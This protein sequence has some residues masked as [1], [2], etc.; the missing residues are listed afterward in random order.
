MEINIILAAILGWLASIFV[1]ISSKNKTLKSFKFKAWFNKQF[2]RL[3][4]SA[5]CVIAGVLFTDDI[6]GVEITAF[7][8]FLAAFSNDV[9]LFI[10]NDKKAKLMGRHHICTK[11]CPT[12]CPKATGVIRPD[13][14][15]GRPYL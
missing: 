7:W 4:V 6:F 14:S 2:W 9:I 10:L 15:G 5:I 3:L 1:D 8:A 12:P 11:D 13:D